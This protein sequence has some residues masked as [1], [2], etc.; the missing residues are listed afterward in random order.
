VYDNHAVVPGLTLHGIAWA[1]THTHASNWHPLTWL[2]HMVDC[3]LYGLQPAG[4]HLTSVVLHAVNAILLFLVLR[5]MTGAFWPSAF[6]A[7]I[8]GVHPLRAESVAWVSERKDVLSGTFFVLTLAAYQAYVSRPSRWRYVAVLLA[9]A[10]GLMSKPMLVTVPVVL[11]LLDYWP[12]ARWT[13]ATAAVLIREKLPLLALALVSIPLTLVAQRD[14]IQ[15][16]DALPL[17]DRLANAAQAYVAYLGDLIVPVGLVVF[18]PRGPL[19]VWTTALALGLLGVMT[20]AAVHLRRTR[21]YVLVGW[22]WYVVMLAPTIGIVQVGIQARADRYTYL[23]QIG[24]AL[25]VA[26]GAADLARRWR[27]GRAVVAVAA[28][29]VS[30]AAT[31][32][33]RAQVSVW[34]DSESPVDA[35]ASRT[36]P[37]TVWPSAI[38]AP[39]Y[40]RKVG[41]TRRWLTSAAPRHRP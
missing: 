38:W 18:R 27:G 17:H 39:H 30:A 26:W 10:L 25:L 9:L 40:S 11:L 33:A 19:D 15:P 8:F 6:V 36:P 41:A 37:T 1:F 28:A 5:R 7:T 4:H 31:V 2:S 32:P 14:A 24:L 35:G 16:L 23:P 21:P 29:A 13:R 34:R 3:Q 22:A 20:A 12:L